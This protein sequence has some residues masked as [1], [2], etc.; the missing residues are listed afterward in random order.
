MIISRRHDTKRIARTVA[1]A[2][3]LAASLGTPLAPTAAA[4]A[5]VQLRIS[6]ASAEGDWLNG[7]LKVFKEELEKAAPGQ[8]NVEIHAG[9]SLFRQGTEVPALQRG[10]LQMSTMTAF[11]VEQ[12]L[13][14]YGVLSAGYM[15]RDYDH[16]INVLRGPIGEEYYDAVAQKMGIQIVDVAYLGTRQVNL[17]TARDVKAPA[18]LSGVKLRMPG[19]PGWLALGKGLGV[20]P[21]PMAISEVYLALK[22]GAIDGQDNPLTITKVNNFQEVTQQIV[23]TSHLVQPVFFAFAKPFWDKLSAPQQAAIRKAARSGASFNDSH[24]LAEEKELVPFFVKYGLKVT[25][26]DLAAFRASVHKEYVD[27]GLAAKWQPGL[28]EKISAVK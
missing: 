1:M 8:F 13:P 11:E 19:G 6:S 22:T 23:L 28:Q 4:A 7:G 12:Q 18:D 10:N 27:S 20:T 2:A 3:L 17:R 5:P 26:P 9:S 24:R 25:T 16:M 14:Q 21:V 15:F